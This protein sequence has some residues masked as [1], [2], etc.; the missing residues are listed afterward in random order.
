LMPPFEWPS[1]PLDLVRR[2]FSTIFL[3]DN[4]LK[5]TSQIAKDTAI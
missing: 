2:A 4:H 1:T 3:P 5:G